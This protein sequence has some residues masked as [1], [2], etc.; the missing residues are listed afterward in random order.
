MD[1]IIVLLILWAISKALKKA[2]KGGKKAAEAARAA[3]KMADM[4]GVSN[5]EKV[6]GEAVRRAKIYRAQ[7]SPGQPAQDVP[8]PDIGWLLEEEDC[9]GVTDSHVHS[10]GASH[11]DDKGCVGGSLAHDSHEGFGKGGSA[12]GLRTEGIGRPGSLAAARMDGPGNL[13]AAHASAGNSG[14]NGPGNLA[15][16]AK[17][18][19]VPMQEPAQ[20]AR[21]TAADM[22][23]AVVTSEILGK[24]VALRGRAAGRN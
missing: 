11:A 9:G 14:A 12:G 3:K 18:E 22:R 13:A 1:G 16:R 2:G 23:R 8:G 21:F 15:A 20:K 19:N 4:T 10:E 7:T 17:P 5:A 24:P 6:I